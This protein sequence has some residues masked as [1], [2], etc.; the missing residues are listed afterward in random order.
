MNTPSLTDDVRPVR[1][2]G[3]IIVDSVARCSIAW[4]RA[5]GGDVYRACVWLALDLSNI[6]PIFFS[7]AAL[8][9]YLNGEFRE[10]DRRPISVRGLGGGLGFDDETTRRHIKRLA[11]DGFCENRGDGMV[12]TAGVYDRPE[13]QQA[14]IMTLKMLTRLIEG[15]QKWGALPESPERLAAI[16]ATDDAGTGRTARAQRLYVMLFS[17][18]V[19]KFSIEN[20]RVFN[21][22]MM[23]MTVFLDV[24]R[25][26]NIPFLED[27]DLALQYSRLESP[28]PDTLRLPTTVRAIS[29][30]LGFPPETMRRHVK[31]L[32]AMNF[33][34]SRAGGLIVPTAVLETPEFIKVI[35]DMTS[36]V[37]LMF[38]KMDRLAS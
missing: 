20:M 25:E 28:I 35:S 30:R 38:K 24:L 27:D 31:K 14:S 18:Y 17:E 6:E 5:F 3:R 36:W 15:L 10:A 21:S 12:V 8:E 11:L 33:I 34:E 32:M 9:R 4:S 22:N 26:N 7:D 37:A 13:I 2:L 29:R 16:N 1:L 19:F 23:T